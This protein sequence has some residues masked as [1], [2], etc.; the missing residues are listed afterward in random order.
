MSEDDTKGGSVVQVPT[1][2]AGATLTTLLTLIFGGVTQGVLIYA[3]QGVTNQRL[4]QASASL[5]KLEAKLE[6]LQ[7]AAA[8][9]VARG[10]LER[11]Q[12][13]QDLRLERLAERVRLLEQR[14]K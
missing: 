8:G 10:D 1:W 12:A 3:Q 11:L 13:A 7:A 5:E 6:A 2:A 4:A 14:P 9:Q